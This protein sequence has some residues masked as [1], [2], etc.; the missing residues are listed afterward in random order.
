MP[1][2]LR[3]LDDPETHY[4]VAGAAQK[5]LLTLGPA[6]AIPA[7]T[8]VLQSSSAQARLLTFG[9]LSL[10]AAENPTN[11]PPAMVPTLRAAMRDA[12]SDVRSLATTILRRMGGWEVWG[13][14]WV[15]RH[16]T[17]ILHGITPDFFTNTP[18]R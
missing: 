9:C 14:Q 7:L 15:R 17:N 13:D 11:I 2:L 16:G 18:P 8:N 5:V 3:C 6:I 1:V 12:D 10:F 4:S